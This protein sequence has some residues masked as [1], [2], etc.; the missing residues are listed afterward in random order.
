MATQAR[1]SSDD[2]S[3]HPDALLQDE[4]FVPLMQPTGGT[5]MDFSMKTSDQVQLG[6]PYN[7][8]KINHAVIEKFYLLAGFD[9][10]FPIMSHPNQRDSL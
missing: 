9:K 8:I 2:E 3:F 1:D 5:I 6:I 4:Y 10:P 7:T